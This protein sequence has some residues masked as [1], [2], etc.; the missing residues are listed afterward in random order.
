MIRTYADF[1]RMAL[2][3]KKEIYLTYNLLELAQRLGFKDVDGM[4][5]LEELLN[6]EP[7]LKDEH[8]VIECAALILCGLLK[9]NRLSISINNGK[10]NIEIEPKESKD[11]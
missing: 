7:Q 3:E 10:W 6:A 9:N 8:R 5:N 1:L 2:T 4:K 11:K